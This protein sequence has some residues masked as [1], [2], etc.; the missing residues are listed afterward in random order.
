MRGLALRRWAAVFALAASALCASAVVASCGDRFLSPIAVIPKAGDVVA[1]GRGWVE[2]TVGDAPLI[3]SAPHGGLL[4]P[5]SLPDRTCSE[6]VTVTDDNTQELARL[7]AAQ[8][9]ARTGK[10]VHLVV[11][12]LRRAKFDANRELVEA[13][14]GNATLTGTWAAYDAFIEEARIRTTTAHGRGLLLDLHGH[15]HAI[16]R[17]ELGYLISAASLRLSDPALAATNAIA[18]SSISRL[19]LIATDHPTPVALLRG[20]T[21]LGALFVK[22]GFAAVPSPTDPAPAAADEYF[23]G[24]FTTE[25]HGSSRGGSVDAIQIEAF[26]TG[27]RDTPENLDRYAG[28]IVSS[29]LEYLS[30]HYG[31]TP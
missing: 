8:F 2:Y 20:P 21:S 30:V 23:T 22:N 25:R 12:L 17:L 31:W 14:G 3:I 13:T 24:G 15:G 6:C 4:A 28:A 26:R 5:T 29:A 11:N 16:P 7:V 1:D 10:R 9:Y 18:T 19:A 27:A